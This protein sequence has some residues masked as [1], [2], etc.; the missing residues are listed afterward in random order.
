[1]AR[2][3]SALIVKILAY[4]YHFTFGLIGE[5]VDSRAEIGERKYIMSWTL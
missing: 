2:S 5:V 4:K 1:M 3:S